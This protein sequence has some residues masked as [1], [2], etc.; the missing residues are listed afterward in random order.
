MR[1]W[2]CGGKGSGRIDEDTG[3]GGDEVDSWEAD[4]EVDDDDESSGFD[5]RD[6]R[7]KEKRR[8]DRVR[9]KVGCRGRRKNT[10]SGEYASK[11]LGLPSRIRSWRKRSRR[12]RSK[13]TRPGC[14]SC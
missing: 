2:E 5:I 9:T 11:P 8:K 14:W 12:K 4:E 10:K 3:G 6:R 13:L 7:G 1:D